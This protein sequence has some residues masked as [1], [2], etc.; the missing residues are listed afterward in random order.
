[1]LKQKEYSNTFVSDYS[2]SYLTNYIL[3]IDL[4]LSNYDVE[5]FR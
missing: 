2:A 1:M 4:M 5:L 3:K